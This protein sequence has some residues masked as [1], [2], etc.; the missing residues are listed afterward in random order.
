MVIYAQ[1]APKATR[2]WGW[3]YFDFLANFVAD[4]LASRR[5]DPCPFQRPRV[6][7]THFLRLS[8]RKSRGAVGTTSGNNSES[9][10]LSCLCSCHAR[11][12]WSTIASGA[13]LGPGSRLPRREGRIRSRRNPMLRQELYT[14]LVGVLPNLHGARSNGIACACMRQFRVARAWLRIASDRQNVAFG[15][16]GLHGASESRALP[17]NGLS[18]LSPRLHPSALDRP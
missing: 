2:D 16:P 7:R 18:A 17:Q 10:L 1:P 4:F 13:T 6:S 14:P 3:P 11:N 8:S 12:A 5:N 9:G 15:P